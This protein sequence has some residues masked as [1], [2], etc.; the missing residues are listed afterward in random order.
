MKA[1]YPKFETRIFAESPEVTGLVGRQPAVHRALFKEGIPQR[2]LFKGY[3]ADPELTILTWDGHA[4][5]VRFGTS[6]LSEA[7]GVDVSTGHVIEV[8]DVPWRPTNLVNTTVELFTRTIRA[9]IGRFPYY[10]KD[11][12]YDQIDSVCEELREIIRSVD[13][14]ASVPG[15]YWPGFV[16]DVQMGDFGT[17]DILTQRPLR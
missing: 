6:G 4:P 3:A 7:I 12:E 2:F 17:D 1:E 10:P 11:A 16:D 8:I 15:S 9:L 13:P 14:E 5:V